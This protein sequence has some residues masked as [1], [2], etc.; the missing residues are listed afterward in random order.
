VP[1]RNDQ[2]VHARMLPDDFRKFRSITLLLYMGIF[3]LRIMREDEKES[4]LDAT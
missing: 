3:N 4:G 2:Q 1:D